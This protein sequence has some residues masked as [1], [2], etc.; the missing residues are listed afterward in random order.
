[1]ISVSSPVQ[2]GHSIASVDV[3]RD[4]NGKSTLSINYIYFTLRSQNVWISKYDAERKIQ[5]SV[6]ILF[7]MKI[8]LSLL[9]LDFNFA[10]YSIQT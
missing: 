1:M 2:I 5:V 7:D 8:L 6:F 9:G 4:D 3:I 10:N